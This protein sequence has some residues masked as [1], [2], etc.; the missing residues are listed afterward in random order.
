M[1]VAID[2]IGTKFSVRAVLSVQNYHSDR[3]NR[4]CA[5]SLGAPASGVQQLTIEIS[6]DDLREIARAGYEGAASTDHDRQVPWLVRPRRKTRRTL[7]SVTLSLA[8][9]Q[10]R[11]RAVFARR[12]M[13]RTMSSFYRWK[14]S[15]SWFLGISERTRDAS[16][17]RAEIA[18]TG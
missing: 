17:Q 2:L 4:T 18:R 10:L 7:W 5:R 11:L 3:W 12:T 15:G 6:E 8:V 1:F 13:V 9:T 14:R 16:G